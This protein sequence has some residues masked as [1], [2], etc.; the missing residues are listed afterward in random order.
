ML[1]GGRLPAVQC[2]MP[3]DQPIHPY[4]PARRRPPRW[5]IIGLALLAILA[6][7]ALIWLSQ[8]AAPLSARTVPVDGKTIGYANAPVEVTEWGDFQ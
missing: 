1:H 8:S 6:L 2:P 7:S 3:T 5:A 4:H